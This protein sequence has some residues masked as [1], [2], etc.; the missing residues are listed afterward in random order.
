MQPRGDP[1]QR[2]RLPVNAGHDPAAS[3]SIS[4]LF[5]FR[6]R[7]LRTV[8]IFWALA[9]GV[10]ACRVGLPIWGSNGLVEID[11][12][13]PIAYR[14]RIDL[15]RCDWTALCLLPGVGEV[16]ARRIVT[17]RHALGPYPS[18]DALKRVRGIGDRSVDRWRDKLHVG[19]L[20]EAGVTRIR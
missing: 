17:D 7:N 11:R 15:N 14:P 4:W 13:A 2:D 16:L 9:L 18:V 19:P 8:T 10:L 3:G 1:Q 5:C 20:T 12:A 6:I